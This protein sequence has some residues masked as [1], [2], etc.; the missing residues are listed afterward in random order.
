MMRGERDRASRCGAMTTS[1][2]VT[3]R[4]M[5]IGLALERS[6]R[7]AVSIAHLALERFHDATIVFLSI[8]ASATSYR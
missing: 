8:I 7:A 6:L 5:A 1:I 2:P 3:G 4:V